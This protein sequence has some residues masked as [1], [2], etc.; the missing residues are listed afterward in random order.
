MVLWNP[1]TEDIMTGCQAIFFVL[2]IL[3]LIRKEFS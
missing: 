3:Y 2:G 1:L